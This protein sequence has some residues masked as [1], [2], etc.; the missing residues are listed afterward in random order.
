MTLTK[1]ADI[2]FP[3]LYHLNP[4]T[5]PAVDSSTMHVPTVFW[6]ILILGGKNANETGG[7]DSECKLKPAWLMCVDC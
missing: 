3:F 5:F 4:R 2:S 6:P 7:D 1:S